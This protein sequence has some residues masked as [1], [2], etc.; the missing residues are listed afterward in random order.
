[1]GSDSRATFRRR[2][3]GTPSFSL[4]L[5]LLIP[6]LAAI[7][8]GV[9]VLSYRNHRGLVALGEMSIATMQGLRSQVLARGT[10]ALTP[11]ISR[12]PR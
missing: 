9:L 8:L 6:M 12:C 3:G 5:V 7:L 11:W 4:P 1:M 10:N 2:C